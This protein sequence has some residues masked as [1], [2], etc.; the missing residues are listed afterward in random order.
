[1]SNMLMNTGPIEA[2]IH[3]K[4]SA[5]FKPEF[6]QLENESHQHNV[7]A[8]SESH[9]K[10]V[11]VSAR[12]ENVRAVARHQQVYR[13][14]ADELAGAVH[15]LSLHTHTPSEW[16]ARGQEVASSPECLGGSKGEAG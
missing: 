6:L 9:F 2:L 13:T 15:A 4:L 8:G 16:Q 14:L 12:F 10:V 7:P 1:M 3:D 5:D 11:L